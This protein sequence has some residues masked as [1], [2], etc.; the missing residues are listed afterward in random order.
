[1]GRPQSYKAPAAS[2]GEWRSRFYRQ[3][4]LHWTLHWGVERP[5]LARALQQQRPDAPVV[6]VSGYFRPEEVREAHSLGL[7]SLLVKP[8]TVEE[9]GHVLHDEIRRCALPRSGVS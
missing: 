4:A 8:D 6:I 7:S 9:L 3:S 5:D 2:S 1:M